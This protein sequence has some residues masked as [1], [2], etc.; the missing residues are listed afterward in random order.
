[1]IKLPRLPLGYEKNPGLFPRYWDEAMTNVEKAVNQVLLLPGIQAAIDAANDA[2]LTANT[3]AENAQISAENAQASTDAQTLETSLVN[4]YI[5]EASFT[6]T[7]LVCSATSEI[8]IQ[9]HT[10]VYGDGSTAAV[11][12]DVFTATGAVAGDVVR[13]FYNDATR[14]GGAVAYGYT[15]DPAPS[16]VQTI[17]THSV[18]S[19]SVPVTGMYDGQYIRPPGYVFI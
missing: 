13:V 7:L 12:G 15:I 1:M 4:S 11:L 14:A 2:A 3:A 10:R 8:T 9:D 16:P 6:G 17:Y 18:G 19:L 5:D